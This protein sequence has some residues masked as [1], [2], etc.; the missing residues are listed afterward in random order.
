MSTKVTI[1]YLTNDDGSGYYLFS[2]C[3]DEFISDSVTNQPV[4]LELNG[5]EFIASSPDTIQVRIPH[6]WAVK[7]GLI[8]EEK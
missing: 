4:Y 6:E 7:L 3:M 5:V 2:D 1:K 8:S